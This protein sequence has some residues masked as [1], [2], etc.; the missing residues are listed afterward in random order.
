MTSRHVYTVY[1][2][3]SFSSNI[4]LTWRSSFSHCLLIAASSTP[5]LMS[6]WSSSRSIKVSLSLL[7]RHT[8]R[9]N[10]KSCWIT[11]FFVHK[12]KDELVSWLDAFNMMILRVL[13]LN[14]CE[15]IFGTRV[16]A[17]YIL[18]MQC[19]LYVNIYMARHLETIIQSNYDD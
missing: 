6:E 2:Y 10:H 4:L 8:N 15:H 5:P 18:T 9:I 14:V 13:L 12:K 16:I 1:T 7:S 11:D 3:K 17:P 19:N